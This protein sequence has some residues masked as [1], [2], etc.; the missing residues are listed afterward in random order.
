MFSL[1]IDSLWLN[2]KMGKELNNFQQCMIF[3]A[4]HVCEGLSALFV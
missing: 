3:V 1:K 2:C 4:A